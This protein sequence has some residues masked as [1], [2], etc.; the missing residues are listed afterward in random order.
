MLRAVPPPVYQPMLATSGAGKLT[1]D[2]CVEPKLDGWR[3]VITIDPSLPMGIEVR[4]RTERFLTSMEPELHALTDLGMRVVLDGELVST[5]DDSN[6]DFYAL[7]QRMLTPRP[8]RGVCFVAFDVLWLDG[9]DCSQ[10][11]CS[12]RRRVLELLELSG[13]AWCT[14]SQ[15]AVDEAEDLLHACKQLGQ[16][17]E[18]LKRLDAR[19][20]LG[21]RSNAWRK[22]KTV[23]WRRDHAPR[24]LP[25]EIRERINTAQLAAMRPAAVTRCHT[26]SN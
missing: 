9:H 22:V 8:R 3:A 13:P 7:G 12:D 14:V 16:E 23:G 21:A 1:G 11:A 18:V 6:I 17:G 10:L 26:Q 24:R 19:Y 4:S 15:F 5:G 2:W 25:K 20:T